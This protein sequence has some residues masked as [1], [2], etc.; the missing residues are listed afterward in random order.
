MKKLTI[1]LTAV[2]ILI[3]SSLA[4]IAQLKTTIPDEVHLLQN[5]FNPMN[6]LLIPS[7]IDG[8]TAQQGDLVMAFAGEVCSGAAIVEDIDLMLNLVATSTDEV[9]IGYKEGQSI[10]L[11]YY[12]AYNNTVYELIPVKILMGSMIYEELGTLY[13]EFKAN[14]L[15]VN[16]NTNASEIKVYPNP[17]N[18]QLHIV[19]EANAKSQ[20]EKLTIKLVSLDGRVVIDNEYSDNQGVI[21]L[22]VAKLQSGEYILSLV[23]SKIKFIQKVIKK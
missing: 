20:G 4:T 10:C 19:V 21:N 17:V 13:A 9:N 18:Q 3:F 16:E 6:I 23:S 7:T 12:S 14:A 2:I 11:E 15:S 5:P 8:I 1:T 22:D